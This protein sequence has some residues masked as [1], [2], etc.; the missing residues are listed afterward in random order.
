[1]N[2]RITI[3]VL[4]HMGIRAEQWQADALN[5]WIEIMHPT[6]ELKPACPHLAAIGQPCPVCDKQPHIT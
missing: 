3:A 1:M 6:V 5:A 2:N 4:A